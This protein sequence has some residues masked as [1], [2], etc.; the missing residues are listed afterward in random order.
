MADGV[1]NPKSF[2]MH[3]G[4]ELLDKY[5]ESHELVCRIVEGE[6]SEQSAD[7]FLAEV[8]S[9]P[10]RDLILS[11]IQAIG[12]MSGARGCEYLVEGARKVGRPVTQ[13]QMDELENN[14]ERALWFHLNRE[15]IF[16][17]VTQTFELDRVTGW[18]RIQVPANVTKEELTERVN[19]FRNNL[20][21]AYLQ[22]FKG[23]RIAVQPIDREGRHYFVAYIEDLPESQIQFED[24]GMHRLK[25]Y[26]PVIEAYFLYRPDEGMLEVKAKGGREKILK[27]QKVF[28]DA[29]LNH[30]LSGAEPPTYNFELLKDFAE[31]KFDAQHEPSVA[32]VRLKLLRF[33]YPDGKKTV[34]LEVED[35][36]KWGCD[37]MAEMVRDHKIVAGARVHQAVIQVKFKP[38]G[39]GKPKSVT[40]RVTYPSLHD[41]RDR[42][43]DQ[44]VR[45]LLKSWG[46]DTM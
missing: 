38:E 24:D 1:S 12:E 39:S 31:L 46:I 44:I 34:T 14:Y 35:E 20:Q 23:K 4:P 41:L 28:A 18:R 15:E 2:L 19:A 40:V 6:K 37:A 13:E 30:D 26:R 25:P 10:K 42:P 32:G 5:A 21:I 9:S 43:E 22:E 17:V 33:I 27:L 8:D 16:F 36:S 45:R 7:R 11:Q 3:I 29:M